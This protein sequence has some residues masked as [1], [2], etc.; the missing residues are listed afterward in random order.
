MPPTAD[1]LAIAGA[2]AG[3]ALGAC[4]PAPDA[5]PAW[6][7]DAVNI[8]TTIAAAKCPADA[9]FATMLEL[10]ALTDWMYR[11]EI[12]FPAILISIVIMSPLNINH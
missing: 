7:G 4:S 11:Q 12:S 9:I 6:S 5:C 8:N 2:A 10:S 1:V 3:R